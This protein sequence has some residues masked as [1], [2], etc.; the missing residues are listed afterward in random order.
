M[1]WL[2]LF[3]GEDDNLFE[4]K[5]PQWWFIMPLCYCTRCVLQQKSRQSSLVNIETISLSK[6]RKVFN[7]KLSGFI[8]WN[9]S[10]LLRGTTDG[11]MNHWSGH[12]KP[13]I[14][15]HVVLY[16]FMWQEKLFLLFCKKMVCHPL[17]IKTSNSQMQIFDLNRINQ[18]NGVDNSWYSY[19]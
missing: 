2:L 15:I 13:A 4:H 1:R 11:I 5:L 9:V 18:A 8:T 7:R 12:W 3:D 6:R 17:H 19:N 10:G 16:Y 14:T